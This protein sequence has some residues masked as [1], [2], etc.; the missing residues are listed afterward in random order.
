MAKIFYPNAFDAS[1]TLRGPTVKPVI[2]LNGHF[3]VTGALEP[4]DFAEAARLGFK[5]IVSHLPDGESARHP[6]GAEATR[7]AAAAGLAYRHVP[8][9]RFDVFSDRVVS[10][11]V[12]AAEELPM[13]ILAH[14]ASGMRSA[15]AWGGAAARFQPA[16]QVVGALVSAGFNAAPLQEEFAAQTKAEAMAIPAALVASIK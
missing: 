4:E 2:A 9:T 8:T 12:A 10:G 11:T 6:T 16:D 13:P 14:C 7:L 5:A 3:S 1:A 15:F